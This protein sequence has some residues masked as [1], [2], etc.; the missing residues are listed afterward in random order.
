MAVI[1]RGE[2]GDFVL[3]NKG[4]GLLLMMAWDYGWRPE[5]TRPPEH[6]KH[7]NRENLPE[8]WAKADYVTGK[9]QRILAPDA[10]AL[11]DA[12]ERA[13]DDLPNHDPLVE[14]EVA[15]LNIPAFPSMRVVRSDVPTTNLEVFG[16]E[17]KEGFRRLIAFC[18]AGELAVW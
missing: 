4:W 18:R 15:R 13:V 17:N 14:K 2:H 10:K 1:L 12:L 6:W 11:G 7:V 9:G 16:G 5:G 8:T 3:N